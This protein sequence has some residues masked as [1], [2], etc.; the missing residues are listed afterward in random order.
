MELDDFFGNKPQNRRFDYDHRYEDNS[1]HA[2]NFRRPYHGHKSNFRGQHFLQ[3]LRINRKLKW[4]LLF[5]LMVF[6]AIIVALMAVIIPLLG[7]LI[8]YISQN[9]IQGIL[10]YITAF[11]EGL[12]KG[13]G[14]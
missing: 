7:K 5:I 3:S 4:L 14:S 12:W 2:Q 11:L 10:E 1:F 13:S 6:L 8:D 9:G